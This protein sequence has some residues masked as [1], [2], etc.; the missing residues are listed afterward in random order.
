MRQVVLW[1]GV[2][3]VLALGGW[4]LYQNAVPWYFQYQMEKKREDM[5]EALGE[6]FKGF[7]EVPHL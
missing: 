4:W 3:G 5:K 2:A 7:P 1:L 6:A